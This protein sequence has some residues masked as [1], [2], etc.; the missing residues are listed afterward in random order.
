MR[1]N[2]MQMSLLDTY[3]DVCQA[4]CSVNSITDN[5]EKHPTQ[6]GSFYFMKQKIQR[7]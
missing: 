2:K 1:K 4:N 5:N 3:D 7:C 6:S